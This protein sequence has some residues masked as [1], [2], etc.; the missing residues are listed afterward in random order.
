MPEA[1]IQE[2]VRAVQE[3]RLSLS[4]AAFRYGITH[5]TLHY[6]ILKKS[7]MVTS[8]IGP[9]SLLRVTQVGKFS[10]KTRS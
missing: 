6:R 2:A 8:A 4:V 5:T 1:V 9:T 7:A 10:M 3:S